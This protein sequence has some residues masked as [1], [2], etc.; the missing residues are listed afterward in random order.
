MK[1]S[2][3]IKKRGTMTKIY[4]LDTNVLLHDPESLFSFDDNLIILPLSVIEELDLIKKRVDE[5]GRNAR[6]ASR[7][8]DGLRL[9]GHLSEGVKLPNGGSVRIDLNGNKS[10]ELLGGIDLNK[11]DNRILAL[12]Y[13]LSRNE[14]NKVILVTKDL[15]LRI[16]ADVLGILT[17]D[18]YS[19]KVDYGNCTAGSANY[20]LPIT[21]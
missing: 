13:H 7:K 20:N 21:K 11:V 17:E 10:Y 19:D 1:R 15:N 18:F 5:I 12:A 4:V 9:L 6:E 14:D 2:Q 16:K 8:L 3:T